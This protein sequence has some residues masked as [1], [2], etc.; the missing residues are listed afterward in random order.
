MNVYTV[1]LLILI[2]WIEA[3]IPIHWKWRLLLNVNVNNTFTLYYL[4]T[5]KIYKK[6]DIIPVLVIRLDTAI[7][8]ELDS[9]VTGFP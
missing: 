2:P 6:Y 3:A 4:L 1:Q 8:L 5:F 9:V 7:L